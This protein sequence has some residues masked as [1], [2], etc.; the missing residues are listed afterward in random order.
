[1]SHDYRRFLAAATAV[2]GCVTAGLLGWELYDGYV[3]RGG[4]ET[5]DGSKFYADFQGRRV[6]GWQEIDGQLYYFGL[7]QAMHTGWLETE[8][9]RFYFNDDGRLHTGW[10]D[11]ENGRYYFDG[12]GRMHTGRLDT[13]EGTFLLDSDGRMRTGWLELDGQLH[14][15]LENGKLHTGWLETDGGRY[16]FGEDCTPVTGWL[17]IDGATY[18]FD[19]DGHLHTGWLEQG[20]Y[21]YYFHESGEMA[22][23]PNQIDGRTYYFTPKGIHVVLVNRDHPVPEDYSAQIVQ[24]TG[25]FY[26]ASD[27]KEALARMLADCSAAGYQYVLNSTYRTLEEQWWILNT[28]TAEYQAA[29]HSRAD[30]YALTL[31]SVAYPGTSEHHLGLAVDIERE[32][33]LNWLRQHC[34]E[35]GF[36]I[37]Y[38][39]GKT[40]IT[41]IMYEPWHFRYVGVEVSMDMKDSGLCLEEY[42]GA[43]VPE[44]QTD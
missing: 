23:G 10:L 20:E 35:Y 15:V 32:G 44:D 4:W 30:A 37:R 17:E 6:S 28:R 19:D 2:L 14:Y 31:L 11:T 9:G 16:Y 18:Y 26:V 29:G 42:L 5:K 7:S 8:E 40:H 43:Y 33:A 1:M 36:I 41:G 34:W 21:R 12:D 22:T 27:C 3:D 38:P 24:F 39:E 13:P 25:V